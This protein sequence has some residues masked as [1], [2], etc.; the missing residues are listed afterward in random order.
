M[1]ETPNLR[2]SGN[3]NLKRYLTTELEKLMDSAIAEENYELAAE[4]QEEL[5]R[6]KKI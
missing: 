3:K 4:I 2:T 6:R 1:E 5:A